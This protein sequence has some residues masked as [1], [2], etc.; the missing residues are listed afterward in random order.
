MKLSE[1]SPEE[2]AWWAHIH[3]YSPE[4]AVDLI[5]R[6]YGD[7]EFRCDILKLPHHG[8]KNY[9]PQLLSIAK[10]K[11]TIFTCAEGYDTPETQDICERISDVYYLRDGNLFFELTDNSITPYGISPRK[12]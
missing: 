5:V 4:Q 11:F 10:P 12:R 3:N 6:Y 7:D 9:P 2:L 8:E 1:R